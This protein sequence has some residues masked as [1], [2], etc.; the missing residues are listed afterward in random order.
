MRISL[1][2]T[3]EESE[4]GVRW[5]KFNT[6]AE[7]STFSSSLMHVEGEQQPT[8]N[9]VS[10][11]L[12]FILKGSGQMTIDETVFDVHE[13]DCVYVEKGCEHSLSGNLS[14]FVVNSPAVDPQ[15]EVQEP[16]TDEGIK[17]LTVLVEEE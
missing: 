2:E 4:N 3:Q 8:R 12:F 11:R 14:A 5:N 6:Q 1:D 9:E 13:A 15:Y 17:K 16:R 10:D 7:F